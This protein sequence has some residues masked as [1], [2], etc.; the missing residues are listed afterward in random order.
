M[1]GFTVLL[2]AIVVLGG[3]YYWYTS[4]QPVPVEVEMSMDQAVMPATSSGEMV[5]TTSTAEATATV[6]ADDVKEFVVT[7]QNFSYDVGTIS[8]NHGDRVR[9]VFKNAGGNHDFVIDEFTGARTK[10]ITGG[11]EETIEFTA[12]KTG[13]FEFYC[14]VGQ[15][16][17]MGM[18]G[19]LTVR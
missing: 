14:S 9:I 1:K 6:T 19:T 2:V 12:D 8:V 7:G 17:E 10:V 4:Q 16:R 13:D 15:H 18:K 3:G 5:H 11:E